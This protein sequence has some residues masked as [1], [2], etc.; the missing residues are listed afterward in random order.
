MLSKQKVDIYQSCVQIIKLVKQIKS[1]LAFT[2]LKSNQHAC[3]RKQTQ[4]KSA[5]GPVKS[6]IFVKRFV[7]RI[8]INVTIYFLF[9]EEYYNSKT[10]SSL[11]YSKIVQSRFNNNPIFF[12]IVYNFPELLM[13]HSCL[14]PKYKLK[15]ICCKACKNIYN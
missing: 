10:Y 6:Q 14:F 13:H 1:N 5:T 3:T 2:E 9:L 15:S 7:N 4:I 11:I 8:Q 12:S